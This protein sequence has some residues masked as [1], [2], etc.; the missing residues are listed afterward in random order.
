MPFWTKSAIIRIGKQ[1]LKL[2][3]LSTFRSERLILMILVIDS[4]P[5]P[6][7]INI[8]AIKPNTIVVSSVLEAMIMFNRHGYFDEVHFGF[9]VSGLGGIV[10]IFEH[11]N[12][13]QKDF[14][15]PIFNKVVLLGKNATEVEFMSNW[16]SKLS[17]KNFSVVKTSV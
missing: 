15:A 14:V 17:I 7:T 3:Q 6:G 5:N 9:N 13:L 8:N 1:K 4:N 12:E 2:V 16:M 10:K 11:L